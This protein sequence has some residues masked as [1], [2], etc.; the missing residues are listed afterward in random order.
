[1]IWSHHTES[2][3]LTTFSMQGAGEDYC[4]SFVRAL[5]A[6]TDPPRPAGPLKIEIARGVWDT[7]SFYV[8]NKGELIVDWILARLLKDKSKGPKINPLLDIRYW[9]LLF[10]VISSPS[11]RP[12]KSRLLP[13][14]NRIPIAPVVISLLFILPSCPSETLP[15][16]TTRV[17]QTFDII[18]PLAVQKFSTEML[19]E[20]FA[21]LMGVVRLCE[22]DDNLSQIGNSIVFAFRTSLGNANSGV[23]KKASFLTV[24]FSLPFIRF[25]QIYSTFVQAHLENW[26]ECI[27]CSTL[28][29][30]TFTAGIE[31]VFNLEILRQNLA[32]GSSS[33]SI[34]SYLP[35]QRSLPVVLRLF[36][37]YIHELKKHRNTLF[38]QGSN[39][40]KGVDDFKTAGM[41]FF[42]SCLVL[43]DDSEVSWEVKGKLLGIVDQENIFSGSDESGAVKST[44]ESAINALGG[45]SLK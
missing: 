15:S 34:I 7:S 22:A 35:P 10:D 17:R 37:A 38:N 45:M 4:Q 3:D 2:R 32:P 24:L 29:E 19:L 28:S 12:I 27:S 5:K 23:K 11:P 21:G 40:I 33:P 43:F 8:P 6:P 30:I 36:N 39:S 16:L 9:D 42:S 31:I 41:A 14:L 26:I 44:A 13:I 20:V 25:A 1:V 18:W